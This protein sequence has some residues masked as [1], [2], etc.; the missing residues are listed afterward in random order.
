MHMVWSV[1]HMLR[2]ASKCHAPIFKLIPFLGVIPTSINRK[3]ELLVQQT[4]DIH[5]T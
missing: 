5:V 3:E 2:K 4:Q 1:Y